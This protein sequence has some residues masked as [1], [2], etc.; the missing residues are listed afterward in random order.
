MKWTSASILAGLLA[1]VAADGW[2]AIEVHRCSHARAEIKRQYSDVNGVDHGLLSVD[3]WMH[4]LRRIAG[5]EI[6]RFAPTREQR[7]LLK[8][9]IEKALY[10]IVDRVDEL[11]VSGFKAKMAKAVLRM[12][13]LRE[14]VPE[15]AD[16]VLDELEA[17]DSRRKLKKLAREELDELAARTHD[18]STDHAVVERAFAHY[19]VDNLADFDRVTLSRARTLEHRARL[20]AVAL[21]A[22]LLLVL[23]LCAL[24]QREPSLRR[25]QRPIFAMAVVLAMIALAV[26]LASPMIEIDARI[27]RVDFVLLGHHLAFDNQVLFYQS[28]SIFQVVRALFE[29]HEADSMF[30]GMLILAFSILVPIGKLLATEI[31]IL[32]KGRLARMRWLHFV[33]FRTGKWSMADVLVVAIFMAYVG[34]RAILD[35]ELQGLSVS[36]PSLS[37]IT[38]NHTSLQPA[39][40]V[41]VAFVLFNLLLS[42]LL[43]RA[44]PSSV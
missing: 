30:V 5:H 10:A 19:G 34:F 7:R 35:N 39:Y 44:S 42:E 43:K 28:K 14:H 27:Q 41:F 16:S 24:V 21:V 18:T 11:R 31:V 9:E 1:I 13:P 38:T 40:I 17:P 2:C 33:A 22:S 8:V 36:T 32:G 6:A 23:V 15:L 4:H 12:M 20:F 37:S 29:T 26:S 3:A 25:L